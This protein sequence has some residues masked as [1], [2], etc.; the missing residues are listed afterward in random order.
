MTNVFREIKGS[1]GIIDRYEPTAVS[2]QSG[3]VKAQSLY[4]DFNVHGGSVGTKQLSLAH[5]L[6][7]GT[8]VV[9]AIMYAPTTVTSGGAATVELGVN[10]AG[11][12]GS[13]VGLAALNAGNVE[14]AVVVAAA[15]VSS[16]YASIAAAAI[17]AGRI[18]IVLEYLLPDD[19]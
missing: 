18:R 3:H 12:L 17:T 19:A 9:R 16:I 1:V 5:D 2:Y 6:P 13:A 10:A 14:S 15:Q 7:A 11:D 4:Y 8:I